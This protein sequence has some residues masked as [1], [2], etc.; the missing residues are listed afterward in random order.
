[1]NVY[2]QKSLTAVLKDSNTK[3]PLAG[4]QVSLNGIVTGFQ[5]NQQGYIRIDSLA[6]TTHSITYTLKGYQTRTDTLI[7]P[8][9]DTLMVFLDPS[10]EELEAVVITSTRSTRTIENI[11]SR[12][13]FIGAEEL[14]EKGNMKPG[15]IR[16]MLN[17]ST[18]I[19]T[20]QTSATSANSSIRIQGLDG[21]Y[22]QLL[23]DGFPLYS[24]AS[25]GLGLLQTPPLDLKQVEIIKGSAST[26]YGGGAIAGLVNLVSKTPSEERELRFHLNGTSAYGLDLNGF[27][28]QR[29]NK[30]LGLTFFG[31][32][33]SNAPYDPAGI[34]FSAIPK[35]ERYTFNPKLFLYLSPK[36][37]LDFGVSATVEDRTGGDMNY[38]RNEQTTSIQYFEKNS[39]QRGS[40]QLSFHHSINEKSTLTVRNS[41]SYF[42]RTITIPD[43]KF[44]GIQNSTFTEAAYSYN[45]DLAEWVIGANILTDNFDE[46]DVP[47][48]SGRDYQQFTSGV[49]LQNTLQ[50]SRWLAIETGLRTDYVDGYGPII[51][52]RISAL[53]T[54]NKKW[55]SR[56]GGG[57]GYKEPS[58]F[59]EES[60]RIQYRGV[61]PVS[62]ENNRLEKSYGAN[63]DINFKTVFNDELSF[64]FNHLFFYTYLNS[65]LTLTQTEEGTYHFQNNPGHMDTRGIETNL[66]LGYQDFK[67][68]LG[69]TY[70]NALLR[71][72]GA[73]K[74]NPLTPKHRL[75]SVLMYE[76][77]DK[78]KIGLEGYYFGKQQLNNGE[79]G[80]SYWTTGFMAE[81]LWENFSLYLNFENFLDTRQTKFE[82]IYS[83]SNTNPVFR[84]IYAPLDGFVVNG[85][86]KIRL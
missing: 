69:Y 2:G 38:L 6:D 35:F 5:S 18:G 50:A 9:A 23:K 13:E 28:S 15:D 60:E 53:M 20:Q 59:T 17:E 48:A 22:T 42:N 4:V 70:T 52:P 49:F 67:L 44:K 82:T 46:K 78:W 75:N 81:R 66:K 72:G 83:G 54:F 61:L 51:L 41:F 8:L 58:I 24:G 11:P 77:E 80:R 63:M 7:Y 64:S 45:G 10:S 26:L 47:T 55:S 36:T 21:R 43:Y 27:F 14:E 30:K 3:Q 56:I 74:Q 25:A 32:R 1:M 68:F 34:G 84:D 65:P 62:S 85:G 37:T 57:L 12:V 86:L 76:A 33:N 16:M 39:T 71:M 73:E 29:F 31:S 79:T 40:T 19:Q